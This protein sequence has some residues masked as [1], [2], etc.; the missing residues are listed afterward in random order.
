MP[1]LKSNTDL[2]ADNSC[3]H[4]CKSL[5]L[6]YS[7]VLFTTGLLGPQKTLLSLITRIKMSDIRKINCHWMNSTLCVCV[8]VQA[9]M[10]LW[11]RSKRSRNQLANI[12]EKQEIKMSVWSLSSLPLSYLSIV[13]RRTGVLQ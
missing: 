1:C 3:L 6:P 7:T 12:W 2:R 10:Y 11:R 9:R 4:C 8:C 13:K 5:L